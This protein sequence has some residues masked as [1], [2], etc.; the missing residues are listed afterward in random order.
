[1]GGNRRPSGGLVFLATFGPAL[2]KGR[3]VSETRLHQPIRHQG[4]RSS[5]GV[6]IAFPPSEDRWQAHAVTVWPSESAEFAR[7]VGVFP[8]S[9][10][11]PFLHCD[12]VLTLRNSARRLPRARKGRRSKWVRCRGL[13]GIGQHRVETTSFGPQ[14]QRRKV[15][16]HVSNNG[17]SRQ[18]GDG[19]PRVK[20]LVTDHAQGFLSAV[21][22]VGKKTCNDPPNSRRAGPRRRRQPRRQAKDDRIGKAL[23][24]PVSRRRNAHSVG[25][26][27][28]RG[29][30]RRGG[31]RPP[32]ART[33]LFPSRFRSPARASR[34]KPCARIPG[35]RKILN[36]LEIGAPRSTLGSVFGKRAAAHGEHAVGSITHRRRN[37]EELPEPSRWSSGAGGIRLRPRSLQPRA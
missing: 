19:R 30:R 5:C 36:R 22:K 3:I 17:A 34:A 7:H 2:A 6:R 11:F 23:P 29:S 25:Q 9:P 35:T 21:S 26:P 37:R 28:C 4:L 33:A 1:M 18:A 27:R 24:G 16:F 20:A 13:G 15:L 32:S 8:F 14:G 10:F 12:K 31:P